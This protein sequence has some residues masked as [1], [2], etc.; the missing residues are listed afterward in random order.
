MNS[1]IFQNYKADLV[2][3]AEEILEEAKEEKGC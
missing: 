3:L 1:I 2:K